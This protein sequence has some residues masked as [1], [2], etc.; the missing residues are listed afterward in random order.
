MTTETGTRSWQITP[1]AA[2]FVL[3]LAAFLTRLLPVSISQFPFNND[4]L[5]E[6]S[7]AS[8]ILSSG[9][10]AVPSGAPWDFSHSLAIP[11]LDILIAFVSS[12]V[13][14]VPIHVAQLISAVV[15]ASTVGGILILG[16]R[17]T[18]SLLG[19][20]SASFSAVLMGTFVF[21]TGSAWKEMLGVS[22]LVIVLIAYV[23]R[24]ELRFRAVALLALLTLSLVHHLVAFIALL[25]LAYLL[26]WSWYFAMRNGKLGRRHFADLLT[27]GI[28]AAAMAVYYYLIS[29][30]RLSMFSSPA[31]AVLF[32]GSI[33]V[34]GIAVIA[35]LSLKKHVKWTFAPFV[36][37]GLLVL[38]L[39]DYFGFIFPYSASAS[40]SY[41]VL[42]VASVVILSLAWYGAEL[43]LETN[44]R[45]R[46]LQVALLVS[47]LSVVA[48]GLSEGL[49]ISSQQI[50][51][52]TF[53]FLDFFLF[54]GIGAAIAALSRSRSR[55]YPLIGALLVTSLVV[56]FPFGYYS[57]VSL[58]VRHDIQA[59]EADAMEWVADQHGNHTLVSD[60]RLS[61][62][63][64]SL[65]DLRRGLYLAY[66]SVNNVSLAALGGPLFLYEDSWT[67]KGT[68]AFPL[69][70]LILPETNYT[71][72]KSANNLLYVGGPVQNHVVIVD[73]SSV[74]Y[75][76]FFRGTR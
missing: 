43:I 57:E 76:V 30:N 11:A 25:V 18:G 50:L 15:A 61:F 24:S 52:R 46:A 27:V 2:A 13:G 60:E 16:M 72:I 68:N 67:S 58:G 73:G 31:K 38:A 7:I 36:G 20:V 71:W 3:L 17:V 29:F 10:L 62:S 34:F 21:T 33:C 63:A 59:Y 51:Y 22:L 48:F 69:G 53:D 5:T 44:P 12:I 54:I 39:L 42:V 8:G 23:R 70:R 65:F 47:P 19:G 32:V 55:I 35:V 40:N 64:V 1:G 75:L 6:C 9:H 41:F 4:S 26:V 14:S 56:S 28:P 37:I 45:Y 49:N 74:G 66:D